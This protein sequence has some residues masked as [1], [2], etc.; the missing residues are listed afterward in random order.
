MAN[1]VNLKNSSSSRPLGKF[2]FAIF[3]IIFIVFLIYVIYL[4][5]QAVNKKNA[6]NP[7][8]VNEVIDADKERP[9]YNLPEVTMGLNQAFS[10]WIYVKDFN[11]KFGEYKNILWKG[12]PG[13]GS[14]SVHSPSLW[15]YPLTNSLKVVTSTQDASA[16]E[17]CDIPNIPLMTWVH[18]CYVLNNRTVDIYI[19]GKLER[20]CALR[21]LPVL[22]GDPVYMTMGKPNPGFYGKVGKTQYFTKSLLPTD[23]MNLYQQGPLGSSQYQIQLFT[24]GKFI[25]VKDSGS[26]ES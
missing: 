6:N 15:L 13:S 23:V 17:S 5:V 12:N 22:S 10:T 14:K 20:S 7:V 8:V 25:S 18:I 4:A 24:D 16:V 9:A 2:F 1:N 3:V 11:Y 19:N 26:F 21:N